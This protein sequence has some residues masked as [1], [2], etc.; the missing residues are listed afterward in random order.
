MRIT[1]AVVFEHDVQLQIMFNFSRSLESMVRKMAKTKEHHILNSSCLHGKLALNYFIRSWVLRQRIKYIHLLLLLTSL[2]SLNK[3][4]IIFEYI[5]KFRYISYTFRYQ[6]SSVFVDLWMIEKI[7]PII[8]E[9]SPKLFLIHFS[10]KNF[11]FLN[12]PYRLKFAKK[13]TYF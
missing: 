8:H 12:D 9:P 4:W 5:K 1:F 3:S 6:V 11:S 2:W 13:R 7:I 10:F